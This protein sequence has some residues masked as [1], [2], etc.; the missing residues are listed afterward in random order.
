V[1]ERGIL[2][3][4]IRIVLIQVQ[5]QSHFMPGTCQ[6]ELGAWKE[7]VSA[8]EE[9]SADVE[10]AKGQEEEGWGLQMWYF[11][12]PFF[13]VDVCLFVLCNQKECSS[14]VVTDL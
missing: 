1:G 9:E 7:K 14:V 3:S 10:P 4:T 11:L 2:I 12:V 8:A 13:P 5:N 6:S